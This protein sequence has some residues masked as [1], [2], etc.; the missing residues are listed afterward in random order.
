[1]RTTNGYTGI[2]GISLQDQAITESMGQIVNRG[3][4]HLGSTDSMVIRTRR[5]I[6]NAARE[7]E[8]NATVPPGVDNPE[9]YAYRSGGVVLPR[10][11]D[12]RE[13]TRELQKAFV[14]RTPETLEAAIPTA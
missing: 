12:W 10:T 14:D 4:E 2:S 13:G 11:L 3:A 6:L 9:F 1:D 8:T 7:F 5:R